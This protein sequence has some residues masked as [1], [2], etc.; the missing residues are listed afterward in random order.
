[1]KNEPLC[2]VNPEILEKSGELFET[3]GCLSVPGD[4]FARVKRAKYVKCKAQDRHGKS[5]IIENDG[6]Y[7]SRCIQHEIDHL[8][9]TL[10]IDYLSPLK[11]RRLDKR[12]E[13][14][15]KEGVSRA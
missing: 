5:I 2:L 8:N 3:E 11:R 7:L 10:F 15:A 12:L 4:T 14:M 13:K 9:G 1:K 6:G